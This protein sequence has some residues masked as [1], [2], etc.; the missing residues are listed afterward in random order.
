MP[1]RNLGI[2]RTGIWL[3][4]I[5]FALLLLCIIFIFGSLHVETIRNK[6]LNIIEYVYYTFIFAGVLMSIGKLLCLGAPS[7][8][9][10]K[11]AIFLA[12]P[13]VLF[14]MLIVAGMVF[15]IAFVQKWLFSTPELISYGNFASVVGLALF[16]F[17]LLGLS[18][19]LGS[20]ECRSLT[21]GTM[22]V[23]AIVLLLGY[24]SE[25]LV[26]LLVDAFPQQAS[27]VGL[28]YAITLFAILALFMMRFGRLLTYL[29]RD[30]GKV[31]R[32]EQLARDE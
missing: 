31:S 24:G 15:K 3:V 2:V 14:S 10:G 20:D 27:E 30:I 7:E 29:L 19:Y 12:V 25:I 4:Y 6:L 1:D 13:C 17:F 26:K 18:T 9:P 23:G 32:G 21:I 16:L 8:T 11:W 5:G 28:G 22:I